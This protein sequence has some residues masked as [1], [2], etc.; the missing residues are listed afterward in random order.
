M[1]IATMHF[2]DEVKDL[3]KTYHKPEVSEQE[4]TM[5]KTLIASMDTPFDPAA[6]QDEYQVKLRQLIEDKVAGKEVVA[7]AS[8][9]HGN[10]IDLMEALKAS[11]AQQKPD[12]QKR[13][14]RKKQQGA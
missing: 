7:A 6:Y 5:A 4:L 14:P 9:P 13:A 3:P 2:E 8:E 10:V 12:K 11:I 1:L